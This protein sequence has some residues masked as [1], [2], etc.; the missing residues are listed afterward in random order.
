M[1]NLTVTNWVRDKGFGMG[2]LVGAIPSAVGGHH[3]ALSHVGKVFRAEGDNL[4]R[5]R[6]WLRYVPPD[7]IWV[8]GLFFFLGMYL[9]V[10]L[11]TPL[12]PHCTHLQGPAPGPAAGAVARD[13]RA[14]MLRVLRLL[15]VLRDPRLLP[16]PALSPARGSRVG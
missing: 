4:A 15:R 14:R 11:P 13:R 2:K 5:W 12:I 10:N 3:V 8:L 6:D 1:G 7:Q 9:K 16:D